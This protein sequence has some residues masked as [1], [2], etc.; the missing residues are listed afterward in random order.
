MKNDKF[1]N[2]VFNYNFHN[3]KA[4]LLNKIF[5]LFNLKFNELHYECINN[6]KTKEDAFIKLILGLEKSSNKILFEIER[7]DVER[8]TLKKNIMRALEKIKNYKKTYQKEKNNLMC[9]VSGA[10]GSDLTR[11]ISDYL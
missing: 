1:G 2:M 5:S 6:Y 7:S 4:I 10:V 8:K 3:E 11:K 9:R